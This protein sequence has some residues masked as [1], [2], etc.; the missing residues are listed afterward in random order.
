MVS[1]RMQYD[2]EVTDCKFHIRFDLLAIDL[3]VFIYYLKYL[4]FITGSYN[5]V[6]DQN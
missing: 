5:Q 4:C 6:A 2:I 3:L 1:K